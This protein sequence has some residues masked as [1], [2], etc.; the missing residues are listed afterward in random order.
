[1]QKVKKISKKNKKNG[2]FFL[3]FFLIIYASRC[4]IILDSAP[5][6]QSSDRQSLLI[7]SA[8]QKRSPVYNIF[9]LPDRQ[10]KLFCKL[11]IADP[12]QKPAL[13]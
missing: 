12:V 11:V 3:P 10:R 4:H 13:Q 8:G 9:D 1:M 6:A 2:R 7:L 5:P